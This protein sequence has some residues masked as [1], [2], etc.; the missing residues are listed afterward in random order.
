M[1]AAPESADPA[2]GLG[3][4]SGEP[5]RAADR[6]ELDPDPSEIHG[7]AREN[8]WSVQWW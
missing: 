7:W 8:L 4:A 6:V 3:P 1:T 5:R 2:A